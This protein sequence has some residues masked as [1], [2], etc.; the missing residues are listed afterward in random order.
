MLAFGGTS[1]NCDRDTARE[2]GAA[3]AALSRSEGV[4]GLN[5]IPKS[6]FRS[7]SAL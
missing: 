4:N 6:K 1:W 2:Y 3:S 5:G 7:D